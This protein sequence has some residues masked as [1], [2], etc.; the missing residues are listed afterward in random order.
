MEIGSLV[1]SR[2]Q[3]NVRGVIIEIMDTGSYRIK[4][5]STNREPPPLHYTVECSE[6]LILISG[7]K[8]PIDRTQ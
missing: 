1:L 7:N 6:D 2:W 3:A 4:W 5:F 8:I